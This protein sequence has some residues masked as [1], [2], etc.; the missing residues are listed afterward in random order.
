M[1]NYIDS[2]KTDT[3]YF[4]NIICA[5]NCASI[6]SSSEPLGS[7]DVLIRRRP[8][9]SV[10]PHRQSKPNFILIIPEK[11]VNKS[12]YKRSRSHDQ[13]DATPIFNKNKI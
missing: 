12:L 3:F 6:V 1:S 5:Y 13:I 11:G 4:Y 9:S 10:K 2:A 8:F 7:Q